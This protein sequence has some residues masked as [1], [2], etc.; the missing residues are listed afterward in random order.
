MFKLSVHF[1]EDS[2]ELTSFA[3]GLKLYTRSGFKLTFSAIFAE[4]KTIVK[5]ENMSEIKNN[6]KK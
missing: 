1:H 3:F 4:K 2:N 5:V 6:F